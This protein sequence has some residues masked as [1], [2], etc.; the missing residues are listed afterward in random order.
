MWSKLADV[1]VLL[2]RYGIFGRLMVVIVV[3]YGLS[4][5]LPSGYCFIDE[6][7]FMCIGLVLRC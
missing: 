5:I 3:H 6:I 4:I 7:E 1:I 2:N